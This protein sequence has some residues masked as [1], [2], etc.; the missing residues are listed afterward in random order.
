MCV[1]GDICRKVIEDPVLDYMWKASKLDEEYQSVAE[2]I[3][4]KV[5][6]EGLPDCVYSGNQ[7]V[8]GAQ[9]GEEVGD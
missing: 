8:H 4:K 1:K 2:T 9:S 3:K 5:D 6:K 7:G